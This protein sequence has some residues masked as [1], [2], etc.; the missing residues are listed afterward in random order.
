MLFNR[1]GGGWY[2]KEPKTAQSRRTIPIPAHLVGQLKRH[3]TKQLKERL[4]GGDNYQN[5]DL[6]FATSSGTPILIRNLDRRHFKPL[7]E[8][9]KLPGMRLYDLRHPSLRSRRECK[10]C[11][12]EAGT[13]QHGFYAGHL[14]SCFAVDAE[15]CDK[16]A[17]RD[18][19]ETLINSVFTGL[20]V[21]RVLR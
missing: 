12:R 4:K 1:K 16:Q 7:L 13:L 19:R 18:T 17:G 21:R 5:N 14:R 3:R 10:G 11:E 9:A 20:Y 8:K 6:V 2:F 15:G